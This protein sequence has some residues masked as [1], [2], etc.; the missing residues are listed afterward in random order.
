MLAKSFGSKS[1]LFSCAY[2]RF[3]SGLGRDHVH[4]VHQKPVFVLQSLLHFWHNDA[5]MVQYASHCYISKGQ[6]RKN[7]AN[8]DFFNSSRSK[9]VK[10]LTPFPTR[11]LPPFCSKNFVILSQKFGKILSVQ[12]S[13]IPFFRYS[14]FSKPH[15]YQS[16]CRSLT[17][18]KL[19]DSNHSNNLFDK[20]PWYLAHSQIMPAI[21]LSM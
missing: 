6:L 5:Q 11:N 19:N 13:W 12:S 7:K 17:K 2:V 15:L 9:N 16:L 4:M 10:W 3:Y 18:K 20:L 8:L 1:R 14:F 21:S